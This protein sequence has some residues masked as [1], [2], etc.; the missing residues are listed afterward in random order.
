MSIKNA[1]KKRRLASAKGRQKKL[2]YVKI[3]DYITR[4]ATI[5]DKQVYL[6]VSNPSIKL[7]PY[8]KWFMEDK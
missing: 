1:G 5:K 6:L 7:N 4:P 3:V 2:D 8:A